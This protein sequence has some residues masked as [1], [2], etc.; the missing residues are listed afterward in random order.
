MNHLRIAF[1]GAA[2]LLFGLATVPNAVANPATDAA[3]TSVSLFNCYTTHFDAQ[4]DGNAEPWNECSTPACGCM[5]PYVGAGVVIEAAGQQDGAFVIT[6]GCQTAYGTTQGP[7]DGGKLPV[8]PFI[9]LGGGG[10]GPIINLDGLTTSS[11]AQLPTGCTGSGVGDHDGDG[12]PEASG[13]CTTPPCGCMC[14]AVGEGVEIVALGQD[15]K[16]TAIAGCGY[17]LAYGADPG[18]V[19]WDGP[20]GVTPTTYCYGGAL[21]CDISMG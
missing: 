19:D 11:A 15:V 2:L 9:F 10:L 4:G 13:S 1:A 3:A 5:C 17:Y 18:D 12:V 21:S 14:P 20:L 16:G 6:S 7:A 8:T